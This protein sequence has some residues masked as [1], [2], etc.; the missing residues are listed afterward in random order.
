MMVLVLALTL[1]PET[2]S[3]PALAPYQQTL[4]RYVTAAGGVRYGQLKAGLAPLTAF[5]QQIGEVS[6]DSHP[7]LF[8]TRQSK[9]AYWINTYN[10]LVLWAMARDY[11]QKKDRL[12]SL[13]G[14]ARFF[15]REKFLVGG[16]QRTLSDIEDNSLRAGFADPRI[17]FAIVCA[18]RGCPWLS[19]TAF[20]E[21]N[22]EAELERVT[23]EAL[24][25]ERNVR[26]DAAA[27][28]V[29]LTS[30]FK[31]FARDFGADQ[32]RL[33]FLARYREAGG[34]ALLSGAWKLEYAD[35]DWSLN[36]ATSR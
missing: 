28:T 19:R 29:R 1:A 17:H 16:R 33:R 34:A 3:A 11:P 8:P 7:Q 14:R 36:D 9:L 22:V 26:V 6:P 23:R 24:N 10:A 18:S 20:S 12:E 2:A 13:L 4:E 30:I 5:V 21:S 31:W 25:Q 32:A 27:R 35:W 15:Y